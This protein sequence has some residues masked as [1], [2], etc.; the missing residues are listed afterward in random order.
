MVDR[1]KVVYFVGIGGIGM[2]GLAEILHSLGYIVRG[3]DRSYSPNLE[4][5]EKLGIAVFVGHDERNVV[6]ADVVVYSSAIAEDNPEIIYARKNKIPVIPRAVMLSQIIHFKKSIVIA[7]SHGKTTT[8]SVCAAVLEMA[9]MQPTVVNGGIINA[10]NTNARLG[11]GNW[12]VVESDESDGSFTHFF[13][14]IGIITNI[15]HE[16]V[17]HYGDFESLKAAFS[18]FIQNIPFYGCCIACADDK[19]VLDVIEN[20]D[21]KIITYGIHNEEAMYRAVDISKTASGI[22]FSVLSCNAVHNEGIGREDIGRFR[23][24]LLGNHNILNLMSVIAMARELNIDIETVKTT[25]AGLTG[26]KRRFTSVGTL[27]GVR[28]I[29]DYAHHPTEIYA[30]LE[31]AKQVCSGKIAVVCQPHRFIRLNS[32]FSDFVDV[33]K[34]PDIRIITPVYKADE[35]ETGKLTSDDL[36]GALLGIPETFMANDES[37][38]E[39]LLISLIDSGKLSNKDIILFTGAGSISKWA[40]EIVGRASKRS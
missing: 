23:A 6:G 13:P 22:E 40:Y 14:T 15:D 28:I 36:Y 12:A 5:L 7:G 27:M 8:T 21:R 37:E 35:N 39:S 2:S 3:S 17:K 33:L 24:P 18:H 4:R 30:V 34:K 20:Q 10:Y 26:V 29:D 11:K 1:R 31:S 9:S 25:F 16:H 32:F 38:L 19:N